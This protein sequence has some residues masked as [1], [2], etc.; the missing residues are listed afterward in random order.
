M[1]LA[2]DDLGDDRRAARMTSMM[3]SDPT[4]IR[5][6]RDSGVPLPPIATD[7]GTGERAADNR[8]PDPA[9]AKTSATTSRPPATAP[10]A[11]RPD[12]PSMTKASTS[13]RSRAGG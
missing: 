1:A 4:R 6:C 5:K 12:H 11:T 13:A 9:L 3:H 8:Q 2:V 7:R 10:R